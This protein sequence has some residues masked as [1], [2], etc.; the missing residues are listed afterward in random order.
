L[1]LCQISSEGGYKQTYLVSD[2]NDNNTDIIFKTYVWDTDTNFNYHDINTMRVDALV[3]ERLSFSP[4]IVDIYGYCAMSMLSEAMMDGDMY[5]IA[6]PHG[7]YGREVPDQNTPNNELIVSNNLTGT[8][9]LHYA[10]EMTEAVVLLQSTEI[11]IV[12]HQDIKPAQFLLSSNG[13]VKL[14]DFNKAHI[15]SWDAEK[16]EYCS[17]HYGRPNGVVRIDEI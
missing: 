1:L 12:V 4:R 3:N 11:G 15:M 16:N 14:N 7:H 17:F 6:A 8:E 5:Q 13:K 9:K 10:L 2:E